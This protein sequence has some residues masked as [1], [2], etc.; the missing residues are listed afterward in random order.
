MRALFAG[1][2]ILQSKYFI[3]IMCYI[4]TWRSSNDGL[5]DLFYDF[6]RERSIRSDIHIFP[7][8]IGTELRRVCVKNPIFGKNAF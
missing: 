8:C 1:F 6:A 3:K 5:I 7:Y 4:L 2:D